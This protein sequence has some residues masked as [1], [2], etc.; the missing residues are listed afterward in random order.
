V[1]EQ[2]D[3][4]MDITYT[5]TKGNI[6]NPAKLAQG[7]DFIAEVKVT[8]VSG[9]VLDNMALSVI[10][11]S[12]WQIYNPRMMGN[13]FSVKTSKP[14]YMDIKDDRVYLFYSMKGDRYRHHESTS[15]ENTSDESDAGENGE[16][17]TP[18]NRY[19]SPDYSNSQVF[20]IALNASFAGKF[21]LP[22]IY[23]EAMYNKSIHAQ[24]AGQWIT[25]T[26]AKELAQ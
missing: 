5:D 20:R 26:K 9:N 7:T 6:I 8:N 18:D 23:T 1:A 4:A 25:V 16:E 11:P 17:N 15:E 2:Q 3:V 13:Q 10:I 12:G 22:G 14:E 19:E 24:S 21:Y